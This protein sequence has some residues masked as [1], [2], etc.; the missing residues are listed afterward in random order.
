MRPRRFGQSAWGENDNEFTPLNPT[1]RLPG[2][3]SSPELCR[4]PSLPAS[5]VPAMLDKVSFNQVNILSFPQERDAGEQRKVS[6]LCPWFL[7]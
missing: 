1:L 5:H 2:S 7:A 3:P 4:L 6:D